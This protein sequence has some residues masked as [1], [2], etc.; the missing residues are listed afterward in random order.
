MIFLHSNAIEI[1][2]FLCFS[3]AFRDFL[4]LLHDTDEK[5]EWKTLFE[6]PSGVEALNLKS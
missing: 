4:L 5:C 1:I 2:L 6:T 3:V